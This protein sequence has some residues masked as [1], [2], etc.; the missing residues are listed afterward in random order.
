MSWVGN[1]EAQT[2]FVR[3]K[4]DA[5]DAILDAPPSGIIL[6]N[7]FDDLK[8]AMNG[9]AQMLADHYSTGLGT[10]SGGESCGKTYG[11]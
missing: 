4:L 5:V 2:A 1:V 8:D 9:A 10:M 7:K 3:D 6:R 11:F